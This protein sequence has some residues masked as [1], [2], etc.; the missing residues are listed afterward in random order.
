MQCPDA[1][2]ASNMRLAHQVRDLGLQ[3]AGSRAQLETY[4]QQL[5]A[6]VRP[7]ESLVAECKRLLVREQ[8]GVL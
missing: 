4:R 5:A 2:A 7:D 3:L 8:R 6:R 1:S